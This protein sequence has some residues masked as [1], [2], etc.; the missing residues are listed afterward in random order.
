MSLSWPEM[1][2]LAWSWA[3]WTS[4]VH[5]ECMGYTCWNEVVHLDWSWSYACWLGMVHL[6]SLRLPWFWFCW[7]TNKK[8]THI[9]IE[10]W[11]ATISHSCPYITL[12]DE[13]HLFVVPGSE[14]F[15]LISPLQLLLLCPNLPQ[16]LHYLEILALQLV[17]PLDSLTFFFLGLSGD[18]FLMGG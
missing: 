17:G 6:V 7:S 3:W 2:H 11:K 12:L 4:M 13:L 5:L 16:A 10:Y 15:P 14:E 8:F 1:V 9:N 18:L